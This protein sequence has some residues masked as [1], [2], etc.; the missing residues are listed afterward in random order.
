M[1]ASTDEL[2]L[3]LE[4][5]YFVQKP[6]ELFGY[7]SFDE[8]RKVYRNLIR[9][10]HPD[11]N[12]DNPTLS[13]TVSSDINSWWS[14][15]EDRFKIGIYG[16]SKLS[17]NPVV[18]TY[19]S[20][21]YEINDIWKTGDIAD[22]YK[23]KDGLIVKLGRLPRD[24]DLLAREASNLRKIATATSESG[25][26]SYSQLFPELVNSF[27]VKLDRGTVTANV[28]RIHGGMYSLQDVL[29]LKGKLDPRDWAWMYRRLLNA[30][31]FTHQRV[32]LV[33]GAVNLDHV[34]IHP[35]HGLTLIDWCY[36]VPM[37]TGLKALPTA[38]QLDY[39]GVELKNPVGSWLDIYMASHIVSNQMLN[40]MPPRM[41]LFFKSWNKA[42]VKQ[43]QDAWALLKE[44]N[45]LI[46]SYW[47]RQF[48]PF[49]I[50]L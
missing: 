32:G 4:Q 11:M 34:L 9:L 44:Y 26:E 49:I 5:L 18:L 43:V 20:T 25:Y 14:K 17:H 48:K 28:L 35:D 33:H 46:D 47:I 36:A 39:N 23:T 24:N 2:Q 15:A 16:T 45:Q 13:A 3:I 41:T 31:G 1:P 6:E 42:S 29:K 50:Q 37:D 38:R 40:W 22:L 8:A 10:A 21:S 27:Q 19:K 30:L 12:P 7:V